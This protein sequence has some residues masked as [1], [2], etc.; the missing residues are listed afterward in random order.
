MDHES[1]DLA[2]TK[3]ITE[4]IHGW[5]TDKEGVF[6]YDLAKNCTGK[7]AIVEIGSWQGKSTVYLGAGSQAGNGVRVYAVDPHLGIPPLNDMKTFDIFRR[8]IETAGLTSIVRP[9]VMTSEKAAQ[10]F[11]EPIELLFIDGNH[12][13]DMVALDFSLWFPRLINGGTIIFHDTCSSREILAWPGPVAV[14]K[15]EIYGSARCKN[16]RI[17]DT[18]TAAEKTVDVGKGNRLRNKL[19]LGKR[20]MRSMIFEKRYAYREIFAGRMRLSALFLYAGRAIK[21]RLIG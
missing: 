21:R 13:L 5:L 8:N 2:E 9:L 10:T 17:V 4:N 6:L 15:K 20:A 16:I 3:K 18:M 11:D 7:G 14:A 12:D 19:M 1:M